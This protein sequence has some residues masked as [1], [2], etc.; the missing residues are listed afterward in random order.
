[1]SS[2][3]I[4]PYPGEPH[5]DNQVE[6]KKWWVKKFFA[7]KQPLWLEDLQWIHTCWVESLARWPKPQST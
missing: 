2:I 4:N 3:A 7:P 6:W 1:M 5:P